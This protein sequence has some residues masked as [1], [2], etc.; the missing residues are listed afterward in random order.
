MDSQRASARE[1]KW[2]YSVGNFDIHIENDYVFR[3]SCINGKLEV[4]KWLYSFGNIDIHFRDNYALHWSYQKGHVK[5]AKW[6]CSLG[7]TEYINM[8]NEDLN[9]ARLK[10]DFCN[11]KHYK[12]W[13]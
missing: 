4:A 13:L 7:D 12:N 5:V 1:A 3:L 11:G 2:L 6:L 10:F 9:E 8:S